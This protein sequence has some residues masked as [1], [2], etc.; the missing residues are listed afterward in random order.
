MSF[1]KKIEFGNY[2]LNFGK[3]KVLI[4]LFDEVVF[5]SFMEMKYIRK[6]KEKGEYFFLDTQLV[7]LNFQGQPP[8]AA[9]AGRIIKN[10]KLTRDQIFRRGGIIEDKSEL[11][12]APS[13]IFILLLDNHRLLF[14]REV[15][16]APT[17]QNFQSTSQY[18]LKRRHSE[19][20]EEIFERAK[21]KRAEDPTLKRA[22]KTHITIEN[23]YPELRITPLSDKQSLEA[24][25]QRFKSIDEITIKLLPTNNEEINND[26]FWVAFVERKEQMNSNVA[27]VRFANAKDGL[28]P[29]NVYDQASA[30]S[31]LGNS[32]VNFKGQDVQGDSLKGNN[33]DFS[34]SVE[35]EDFPKEITAAANEAYA[36]FQKLAQ[37]NVIALPAIAENAISKVNLIIDRI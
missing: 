23:P 10:T 12:T 18:C 13:S 36:Q 21:Q 29:V 35:L 5:P 1:T 3:E 37:V 28:D 24:F 27:T 2:T 34:L 9:I 11:E 6:L 33:E 14:C 22:T 30:A 25:V 32:E 4:D 26:D 7:R 20:I 16:G 17:I 31:N 8:T 19:F 15:P